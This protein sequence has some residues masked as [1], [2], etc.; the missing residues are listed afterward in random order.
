VLGSNLTKLMLGLSITSFIV[1]SGH[2]Q[3]PPPP[4]VINVAAAANLTTPLATIIS[5][6][7]SH[8]SAQ[9]Y[10]V[11]ATYA[12]SGLLESQINGTCSG[13]TPNQPGY[14]LFLSADTSHPQDL[15]DNYRSLV[16]A[17]NTPT[18]P[19]KYMIYY[20]VGALDLYTNT[21]GSNVSSGL[22]SGWSKVGIADPSQAPYGVA[23]QQVL[24]NVYGITLPSSQVDQYSNITTTFN[25]VNDNP[26]NPPAE[27]YG[28]V[29]KSQICS[30][31]N[32]TPTYI[33]VSHQNIASGPS[34][35][36][37]ITQ[38]GVE[39][40]HTRT[41][42]QQTALTAFVQFLTGKNFSGG[43]VSPNGT[44]QLTFYCY[45]LPSNPYP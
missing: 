15:I 21:T 33:G 32:T 25:A 10:Q 5:Q 24:Q 23:A 38:G 16:Y 18:T 31:G 22:P 7:E 41:T 9:N 2:A 20:A 11:V 27:R 26:P 13:C 36:D 39:I 17:Y 19:A 6:Y 34:T 45:T 28:F 1:A 37:P 42:D 3:S 44:A 35:Y 30:N 4:V 8:Y 14:D 29:A 40:T 12:S 43:S